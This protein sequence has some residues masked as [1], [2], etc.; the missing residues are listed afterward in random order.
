MA[1]QSSKQPL[2]SQWLDMIGSPPLAS[3]GWAVVLLCH[4]QSKILAPY[5]FDIPELFILDCTDEGE[6][7]GEPLYISGLGTVCMC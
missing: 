5:R 7:R 3:T 1:H 4:L 2:T 6:S